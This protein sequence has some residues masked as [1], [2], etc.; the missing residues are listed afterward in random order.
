MLYKTSV[1][2]STVE[3]QEQISDRAEDFAATLLLNVEMTAEYCRRKE[4]AK[5]EE[6]FAELE[7]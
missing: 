3:A 6:A 7:C 4:D 2:A 1:R 5:F